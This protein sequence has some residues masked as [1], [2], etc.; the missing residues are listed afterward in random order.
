MAEL[1]TLDFQLES[2]LHTKDVSELENF[3][4]SIK[5]DGEISGKSKM[6]I[7]KLIRKSI[8]AKIAEN[9]EAPEKIAWFQQAIASLKPTSQTDGELVVELQKQLQE[10][11]QKQ[12]DE[13][14][15]LMAKLT[16]VKAGT[17]V[18]TSVVGN[19]SDNVAKI[20]DTVVKLSGTVGNTSDTVVETGKDV[21]NTPLYRRE[22][23]ISGQIGEPGQTDKLTFVS[24][25]HQMDSGLK[26]KYKEQEIIDAVIRAISPHSSLRSYVETLS[27]VSLPKLRKILRVH[28]RAKSASELYQQLA[29]V[30]QQ[31]KESAQQFLLRALDLRNKVGFASKEADCE[32][33]YDESLIQKTFMKSFETGLRDDILAA[34]LRPILRDSTLTDEDLMRQVNE[35]ASHQEERHSKLL[36]ERRPAKVNSCGIGETAVASKKTVD[37]S[38]QILAEI[39]EIRSEVENLKLQQASRYREKAEEHRPSQPQNRTTF[40]YRGRG[41][42][43]CKKRGLGDKCQ[44]CFACGGYG[45]IASECVKNSPRNQGNEKRLPLRWDRE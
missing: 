24:L 25:T 18:E 44:H 28:Y 31:P 12:Q 37:E 26:R 3:A 17:H 16:K 10:L 1:E 4:V 34:N 42:Q 45:H 15:D 30:F 7:T 41:C 13:L 39:R 29:T 33:C 20:S 9:I 22:F 11:K 40:R 21:I 8:E 5:V 14:N 19:V 35:L 36:T 38:K 27:D 23:K 32:V 2:L 43:T 6:A